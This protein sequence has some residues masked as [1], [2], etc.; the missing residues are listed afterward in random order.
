[1]KN[2]LNAILA[3]GIATFFVSCGPAS[4]KTTKKAALTSSSK[5][6]TLID[7]N[8]SFIELLDLND[9]DL[10]S[11][12]IFVSCRLEFVRKDPTVSKKTVNGKVI[13]TNKV[14]TKQRIIPAYSII[15]IKETQWN[16]VYS[17]LADYFTVTSWIEDELFEFYFKRNSNGSFSLYRDAEVMYNNEPYTVTIPGGGDCR[18]MFFFKED[19]IPSNDVK[20]A[21]GEQ[22]NL[23]PATADTVNKM[24]ALKK[25]N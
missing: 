5:P 3:I 7:F 24:P 23:E 8:Q 11:I 10:D 16:D 15:K 4:N 12:S 21:S 2:L 17:S 9:K 20:I 22:V 14:N 18:L 25:K 19:Y 6:K 1:M 13:Y